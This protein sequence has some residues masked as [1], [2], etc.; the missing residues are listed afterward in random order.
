MM[1]S[2][3]HIP[4]CVLEAYSK[5]K[6]TGMKTVSKATVEDK[7]LSQNTFE[8]LFNTRMVGSNEITFDQLE[9][10]YKDLR[11]FDY[12]ES[13]LVHAQEFTI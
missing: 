6:A 12:E 3:L 7:A 13:V 8:E 10:M 2:G 1:S 4:L 11:I 9:K 5:T